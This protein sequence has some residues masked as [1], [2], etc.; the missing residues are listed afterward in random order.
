MKSEKM[1][2]AIGQISDDKIVE[3]DTYTAEK[4]I[5]KTIWF[6]LGALAACL[7][8][9]VAVVIPMMQKGIRENADGGSRIPTGGGSAEASVTKVFI[10]DG[11]IWFFRDYRDYRDY[12]GTGTLFTVDSEGNE[13]ER[14][15]FPTY[16]APEYCK[17]R[18][19]FYYINGDTLCSYNPRGDI[20]AN[21]CVTGD[22]SYFVQAVTDNYVVITNVVEGDF[23]AFKHNTVVNLTTNEAHVA[24][25][26]G[27]GTHSI[28]DTY[29][30]RI[31]IWEDQVVIREDQEDY[32]R[33]INLYD[34]ATDSFV[35]LYKKEPTYTD[36]ISS[37]CI[38]G[39][40]FY[41]L[42]GLSNNVLKV[43]E[44]FD[45]GVPMIQ[46]QVGEMNRNIVDVASTD[47]YLICAVRERSGQPSQISFYFL[48]PD[49]KFEHFA[50]WE[51]ARYI[52]P[53]SLRMVV[54]DGILAAYILTQDDI[55]IYEL[56]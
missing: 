6:R 3:A 54:A 47:D 30:D 43:I 36:G 25:G 56:K 16:I 29:G 38:L 10:I 42:E 13:I 46:S 1:F 34:C 19:L 5:T 23:P 15:A 50:T 51:D 7:I 18:G 4:K 2:R 35:E 53:T 17:S 52:V 33:S 9:V 31:I 39:N 41:F 40:A 28:L 27:W 22:T 14:H 26:L 37:G 20:V 24:Y 48:Y 11:I 8:L 45:S 12:S 55:F 32:Y 44:S 49:G 21:V